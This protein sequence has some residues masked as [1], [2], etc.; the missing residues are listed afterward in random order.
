[1]F[2]VGTNFPVATLP[3]N[4]LTLLI[5]RILDAG[6]IG[7]EALYRSGIVILGIQCVKSRTRVITELII[8]I[9]RK[10]IRCLITYAVFLNCVIGCEIAKQTF[11]VGDAV[12]IARFR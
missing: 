8:E 7:S 5:D 2:E 4:P 6:E 10:L 9:G 12:L 3:R 11:L 1:M